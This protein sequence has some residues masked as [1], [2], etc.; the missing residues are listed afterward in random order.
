MVDGPAEAA[1]LVAFGKGGA[2]GAG[3]AASGAGAAACAPGEDVVAVGS[4]VGG[5]GEVD[6]DGGEAMGDAMNNRLV[7][8][9]NRV[10]MLREFI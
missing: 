7:S 3:G 5:Q 9:R 1:G 4:C 6:D 2:D 8:A 10:E